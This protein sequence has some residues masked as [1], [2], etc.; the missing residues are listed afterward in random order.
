MVSKDGGQHYEYFFFLSTYLPHS[1]R[2][3]DNFEFE[4]KNNFHYLK[5]E[6]RL[7]HH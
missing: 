4:K 2:S 6:S 5:K 1:I 7:D 3:E